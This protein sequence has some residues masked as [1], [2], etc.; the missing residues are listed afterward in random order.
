MACRG[1]SSGCLNCYVKVRIRGAGEATKLALHLS[2]RYN[3]LKKIRKSSML[4][5]F[6][7]IQKDSKKLFAGLSI[8]NHK[9]VCEAWMNQYPTLFYH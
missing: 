2:V 6:F 7:D 9:S 1:N 3:R 8:A 5:A 4:S